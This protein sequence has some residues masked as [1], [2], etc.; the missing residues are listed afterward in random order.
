[1]T[2][3][4]FATGYMRLLLRLLQAEGLRAEELFQGTGTVEADLMRADFQMPF[5]AQMRFCQN[6]VALSPSGLGLNSGH[7]LQIAAHG[8]LGTVMQTASDL[9]TALTTFNELLASRAS[10]YALEIQQSNNTAS[11]KVEIQ[12][13]PDDL[14]PFFSE[15]ILF[16]MTHCIS[17]YTG[18][19]SNP[20]KYLLAYEKPTYAALY[21]LEFGS[22][23]QFGGAFTSIT[24][25]AKLLSLPS[26]EADTVAFAESVLRCKGL[27][28]NRDGND[29][30][31]G[32]ENFILDNPGKLW[33]VEELGPLFA[34]S[35]RT[36]IRR[37]KDTG[38]SFQ[39]LRD[40]VL[41][42]QATIYLSAMTVEAAALSLGF[43][44]SSSFRRTFKRWYGVCPSEWRGL[45]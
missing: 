38:T 27:I 39:T 3:N 43:A 23:V 45:S 24:F 36:L 30:V 1:M 4:Y 13:L 10:F 41:K 35:T 37:L 16:T 15:C 20:I 32:L 42:R 25:D 44:D 28:S 8:A 6:A 2:E 5:A 26:P 9:G 18:R 7:Q 34:I 12:G 29:L 11:I 40:N 14:I 21:A 22:S 19:K 33:T 31:A 17:F